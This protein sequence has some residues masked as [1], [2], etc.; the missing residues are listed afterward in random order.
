MPIHVTADSTQKNQ[1]ICRSLLPIAENF[2]A[3]NLWLKEGG[4]SAMIPGHARQSPPPGEFP[5]PRVPFSDA[6]SSTDVYLHPIPEPPE[7]LTAE[8][9]NQNLCITYPKAVQ[10]QVRTFPASTRYR[11]C[12]RKHAPVPVSF[13]FPSGAH[14]YK[15]YIQLPDRTR[16]E[17]KPGM[18]SSAFVL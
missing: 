5:G 7:F 18:T 9:R 14:S 12:C 6:I 15:L 8:A 17:F 3:G 16:N 1:L 13:R 10:G 4:C 2:H 11:C